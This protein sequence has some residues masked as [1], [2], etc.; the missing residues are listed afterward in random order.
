[1]KIEKIEK[2]VANLHGKTKYVIHI[3]NFKQALNHGEK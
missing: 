2:H 1:M 3:T